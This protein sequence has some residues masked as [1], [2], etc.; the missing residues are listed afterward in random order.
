MIALLSI[1][2]KEVSSAIELME[3][4][5]YDI[6]ERLKLEGLHEL[7]IES[8][9]EALFNIQIATKHARH[10]YGDLCSMA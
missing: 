4:V 7:Q 9:E 10:A 3:G 5:E 2:M 8:L 1:S 6:Q